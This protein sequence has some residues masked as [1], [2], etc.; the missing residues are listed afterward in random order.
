MLFHLR[1]KLA[2]HDIKINSKILKSSLPRERGSQTDSH[3]ETETEREKPWRKEKALYFSA[4]NGISPACLLCTGSA[5]V[6]PVSFLPHRTITSL[7]DD[8]DKEPVSFIHHAQT[9]NTGPANGS[10]AQ[11]VSNHI[12]LPLA[13]VRFL[14]LLPHLPTRIE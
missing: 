10:H 4:S 5:I 14:I 7:S 6:V 1:R 3:K 13:N 12:M 11:T 2:V 8:E 9:L